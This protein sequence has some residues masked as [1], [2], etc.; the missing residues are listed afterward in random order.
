MTAP[1][2]PPPAP[3]LYTEW[4][5]WW[6]LLSAPEMY[7]EDAAAYA[8]ILQQVGTPPVRT[9]LELGCGGGNNA[10]FLSAH[11][12]MTLTDGSAE[13]LAVSRRL[14]PSCPHVQGDMRTLRLD[15][16]FD[17]VFVHDAI[18]YMTNYDDLLAAL[19]TAFVHC[20]SGG[21][22]LFVPDYTRETFRSSTSHGGHDGPDRSLRYLQW[23]RDP[24]PQDSQYTVDFAL[25]LQDTGQPL[26]ILYD[27]HHCG[28]FSVA[29]W[30]A[31]LRQTGFEPDSMTLETEELEAGSY[32]VFTGRKP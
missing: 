31:A 4:A 26:Q 9:C 20:R 14:N 17:A 27:Q 1:A 10:S 11:F 7:E 29:E 22:A 15:Q 24:D 6:P 30:Y 8:A 23:D 12:E 25:M 5:E 13:M 2:S 28:L 21:V 32:R 19:S 3:R 18:A 16:T